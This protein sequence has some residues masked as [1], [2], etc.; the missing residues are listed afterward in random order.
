MRV[1][2]GLPALNDMKGLMV[3][4]LIGVLMSTKGHSLH[5]S[6]SL[7][8]RQAHEAR[9][10]IIEQAYRNDKGFDTILFIDD[11]MV[12]GPQTLTGLLDRDKDICGVLYP[13]RHE[14]GKRNVFRL[15][16][17]TDEYEHQHLLARNGVQEVDA[18]GAGVLLVKRAVFDK[19]GPPWFFYQDGLTEDI[20]FCKRST[21]CGFQVWCDTDLPVGHIGDKI[22]GVTLGPKP[23]ENGR[24]TAVQRGH[25]QSKQG[26][27][28]SGSPGQL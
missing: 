7:G 19:I 25:T 3:Q 26:R 16:R 20:A 24:E 13:G 8:V 28:A 23:Q 21:S 5:V 1:I 2:V 18:I 12:F 15:D 14:G 4:S 17:Q 22:Y 9:N 10:A 27:V 11:D 6:M